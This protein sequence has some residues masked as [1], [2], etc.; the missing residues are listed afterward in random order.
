MLTSCFCASRLLSLSM[1]TLWILFLSAGD[2]LA[3]DEPRA[4]LVAL[5]ADMG[6]VEPG[7]VLTGVA[8]GESD[9]QGD[10]PT[11]SVNARVAVRL[12]E[13]NDLRTQL[14]REAQAKNPDDASEIGNRD[15]H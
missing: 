6:V 12:Q 11:E 9:A 1:I 13:L 3:P 5:L 15:D 2:L 8:A 7:V 4:P 14:A 10:Y